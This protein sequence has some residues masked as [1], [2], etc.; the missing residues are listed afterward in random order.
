[1]SCKVKQDIGSKLGQRLKMPVIDNMNNNFRHESNF[2]YA[3]GEIDG[4]SEFYVSPHKKRRGSTMIS[5]K[6]CQEATT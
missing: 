3:V 2:G 1:M 4:L 6:G 5:L